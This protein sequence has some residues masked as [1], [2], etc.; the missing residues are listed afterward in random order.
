MASNTRNTPSL[1][2]ALS[3]CALLCIGAC[4]RADA[5]TQDVITEDSL[6]V[7]D[8]D[9][10]DRLPDKLPLY[11]LSPSPR[12]VQ[13]DSVECAPDGHGD[14]HCY[15]PA[16]WRVDCNAP[17]SHVPIDPKPCREPL[18]TAKALEV[19]RTHLYKLLE[20]GG[21]RTITRG[22]VLSHA[23]V[24]LN[25]Q[26]EWQEEMSP[27]PWLV[28]VTAER[29]LANYRVEGPGS[30]ALAAARQGPVAAILAWRSAEQ[31]E[32]VE[33]RF[34]S[35]AQ[36]REEITQQL[37]AL[38]PRAKVHVRGI[39]LVYYDSNEQ[40]IQPAYRFTAELGGRG[41]IGSTEQ[42]VGY[43]AY[44]ETAERIPRISDSELAR[45]DTVSPPT[46][47][48]TQPGGGI[49]H[50]GRYVVKDDNK[51]WVRDSNQFMSTLLT[52]GTA[53]KFQ[54][55][56]DVDAAPEHFTKDSTKFVN[57]VDLALLEAHG[58]AWEFSTERNCC[59]T[60]SFVDEDFR[61]LGPGGGGRLKHLAMHSC[62]VLP[63]RPDR[64]DWAKPWRRIF[65]GL[66]SVLG[67]RSSMLINDGAGPAFAS[68]LA[69]GAPVMI[70]WISAI[71][72]L[73]IYQRKP[74]ACTHCSGRVPMGR[75]AA[76]TACGA[77]QLSVDL[78]ATAPTDCLD[79]WWIQDPLM[80]D[81]Q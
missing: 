45:A 26:G 72:S 27:E 35:V 80:T 23:R 28:L 66:Y 8:A 5:I 24:R 1:Q 62:D 13:V 31:S 81:E 36:A 52:Q 64:P 34:Q 53:I 56:Q 32:E 49:V 42:V 77:D 15:K 59:K 41:H 61:S 65:Q 48:E 20:G 47:E 33:A 69:A 44:A 21:E 29:E 18:N 3:C 78:T 58:S 50:V 54:D 37:L 17:T 76:I 4:I 19:A 63:V 46:A 60:V 71:S 74:F 2:A 51:G 73:N 57:S 38:K 70:A 9:V 43:V 55:T 16:A 79:A 10:P 7:F 6:I 25:A 22:R 30:R 40:L 11:K 68:E 12:T 14:S 67:Y 75:P 39:E